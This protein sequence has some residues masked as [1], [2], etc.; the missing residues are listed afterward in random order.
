MA[1]GRMPVVAWADSGKK[2]YMK[3]LKK[4]TVCLATA[5]SMAA[6]AAGP[7]TAK[8]VKTAELAGLVTVAPY[9]DLS[10]KVAAFGM[11]IGNPVVPA[12]LLASLQQSAVATY[13]PFRADKPVILASYLIAP[14]KSDEVIIYPSVDRVARTALA[15]PGSERIAKDALHLM[16]TDKN[17]KE[18]Y[19]VFENNGVFTAF[20]STE[21]LARQGLAE[22]VP[23]TK[24][25]V[26][27]VRISLRQPGVKSV[28]KAAREHGITNVYEIVEGFSRLD[29]TFD[30]DMHGLS[31]AF[32]GVRANGIADAAYKARF[33]RDLHGVFDMI[34]GADSKLSPE[35]K[36]STKPG[37]MVAGEIRL[38]EEQLKGLG[39]DFNSFVSKQ[40]SGALSGEEEARKKGK[41]GA[42]VTERSK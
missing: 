25:A 20:A 14:G 41:K 37:G 16:P 11:L 18:R 19:A 5:A 33:E 29:L 9:A 4:L 1:T 27:L 39:K 8:A 26:P 22:G 7:S 34:G 13:G 10:A 30:M 31:L 24:D 17:P 2:R 3:T 21:A 40:M 42:K 12:L 35:I 36:V 6:M 38:T 28:S 23:S 32:T 15:N